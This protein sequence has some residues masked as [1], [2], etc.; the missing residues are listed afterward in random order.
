MRGG[1]WRKTAVP[2]VQGNPASSGRKP[3]VG[4]EITGDFNNG[5]LHKQG[6]KVPTLGPDFSP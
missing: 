3:S 5:P 2:T 1:L 4:L 6:A